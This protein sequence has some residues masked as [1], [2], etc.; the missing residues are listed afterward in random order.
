MINIISQNIPYILF[1]Y[2]SWF[3]STF[4]LQSFEVGPINFATFQCNFNKELNYPQFFLR[5]LKTDHLA[6]NKCLIQ[7][8]FMHIDLILI[9]LILSHPTCLCTSLKLGELNNWH[10]SIN[11][12]DH[13]VIYLIN[14]IL[15]AWSVTYLSALACYYEFL[16]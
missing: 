2:S 5:N 11:N 10:L 16:T 3:K 6:L 14:V 9:N 8:L 12:V 15:Y 4:Y 7:K 13:L 1:H